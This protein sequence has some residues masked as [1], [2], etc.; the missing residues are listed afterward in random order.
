M[1]NE[2]DKT[3]QGFIIPSFRSNAWQ[4]SIWANTS[5]VGSFAKGKI[6]ALGS[7][8]MLDTAAGCLKKLTQIIMADDDEYQGPSSSG[9]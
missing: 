6:D 1:S 4:N 9:A 8:G 7:R 5:L 2:E 3:P